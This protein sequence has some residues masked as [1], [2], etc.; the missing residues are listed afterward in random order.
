MS[1]YGFE[2]RGYLVS[3][4]ELQFLEAGHAQNLKSSMS[5]LPNHLFSFGHKTY[6]LILTNHIRLW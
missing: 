1:I 6:R 2:R 5:L 3:E 4:S